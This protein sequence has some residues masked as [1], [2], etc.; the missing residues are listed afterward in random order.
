MRVI[1][2]FDGVV[3]QTDLTETVLGEL[4]APGWRDL[5]A[6]RAA[7][8][9]TAAEC[10][11]QQI[12]LLEG[13]DEDLDAV[14]AAIDLDPAFGRFVTWCERQ[15]ISVSIVSDGVD[16]FIDRVLARH[17]LTH[18]ET[19]ANELTGSAGRRVLAQPWAREGCAAGAGVCKCDVAVIE[20]LT[21]D[22][23]I[24]IGEGRSDFCASARADVLF[25]RGE[26]A[27]Y[28]AARKRGF[29]PFRSLDD[30]A[31]V[32]TRLRRPGNGRRTLQVV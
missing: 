29:F 6:M 12:A 17:G 27:E 4:A 13:S 15:D 7:G 16:R 18:V 3:S 11:R 21:D 10:L 24:Y 31:A 1:C 32:L 30:V 25:A 8:E 2:S 26:L 28:A 5:E 22:L 19:V 9:I 23:L 14:L 20:A